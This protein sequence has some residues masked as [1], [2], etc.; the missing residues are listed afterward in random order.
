MDEN[1]ASV[2][3]QG[4]PPEELFLMLEKSNGTLGALWTAMQTCYNV[5]G[6]ISDQLM[7]L[8]SH[9]IEG[10]ARL[11]GHVAATVLVDDVPF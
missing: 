6:S 2:K 10:N 8:L 11:I 5:D 7:D 9:Q 1:L 4:R 3:L